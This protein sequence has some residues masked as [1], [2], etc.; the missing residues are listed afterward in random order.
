MSKRQSLMQAAGREEI[1]S[2]HLA[3]ALQSR[4]KLMIL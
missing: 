1:Q 3:D 2:A 4:P